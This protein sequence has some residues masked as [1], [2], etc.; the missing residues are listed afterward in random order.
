MCLFVLIYKLRWINCGSLGFVFPQV[1]GVGFVNRS[2]SN[3]FTQGPSRRVDLSPTTSPQFTPRRFN[4]STL[5]HATFSHPGPGQSHRFDFPLERSFGSDSF[6]R[7]AFSEA[8]RGSRPQASTAAFESFKR[9]S[10]RGQPAFS[11][12]AVQQSAQYG[13]RS[14]TSRTVL[15]QDA[16]TVQAANGD[17]MFGSHKPDDDGLAWFARMRRQTQN[18]N[19]K[20]Y[21]ASMAS[22][23]VDMAQLQAELPIKAQNV[24][25][26]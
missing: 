4:H 3:K 12:P 7:Y 16:R 26:V 10:L 25:A 15:K 17:V 6:R 2:L 23:E 8:P 13:A 1:N 24:T 19:V 14:S 20:S 22:D 9:R 21:P 5:R 11:T 18:T